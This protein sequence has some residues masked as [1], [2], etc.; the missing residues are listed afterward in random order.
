MERSYSHYLHHLSVMNIASQVRYDK[1]S[2][3]IHSHKLLQLEEI[4]V[5]LLSW[6]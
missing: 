5:L 1:A 6:G 2:R 4:L 3:Y